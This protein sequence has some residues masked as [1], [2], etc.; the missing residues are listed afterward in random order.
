MQRDGK[1]LHIEGTA[2][3][4][5]EISLDCSVGILA[6]RAQTP[7]CHT[8]HGNL[9]MFGKRRKFPRRISAHPFSAAKSD[10]RTFFAPFS[11]FPGPV[12]AGESF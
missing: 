1:I 5:V 11:N 12:T 4:S 8:R 2:D 6:D 10:F 7:M 9:G 3:I